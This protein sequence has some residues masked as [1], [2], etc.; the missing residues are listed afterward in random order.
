MFDWIKKIKQK[1]VGDDEIFVI[2]PE[3]ETPE[4]V[5]PEDVIA[6]DIIPDE[7]FKITRNVFA[8][9]KIKETDQKKEK[10]RS[11]KKEIEYQQEP[12]LGRLNLQKHVIAKRRKYLAERKKYEKEYL[13]RVKK[14]RKS[15]P[16]KKKASSK[17]KKVSVK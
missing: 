4:D 17:K 10:G 7:S 3:E 13:A 12:D 11:K 8:D 14:E 16:K 5:T 1:K 6:E 9:E 15:K 2:T